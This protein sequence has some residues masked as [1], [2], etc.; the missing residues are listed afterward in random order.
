MADRPADAGNGALFKNLKKEKDTHPDYKGDVTIRGEKFWISAW[1][2]DGAK[3]KYMSL[4][5]RPVEEKPVESS[6]WDTEAGHQVCRR[7]VR[8]ATGGRRGDTLQFGVALMAGRIIPLKGISHRQ[9]RQSRPRPGPAQR[10]VAVEAEG[11]EA[12]AG[13]APGK[14]RPTAS[15]TAAKGLDL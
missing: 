9:A 3:G 7:W 2:K 4:A 1:L 10:V 14:R 13:R 5:L 11:I 8:Q 6:Q 15:S 12:R